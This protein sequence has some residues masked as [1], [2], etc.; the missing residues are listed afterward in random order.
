MAVRFKIGKERYSYPQDWRDVTLGEFV[1]FFEQVEALKPK[2]A[3][4]VQKL[5]DEIVE[6][7]GTTKAALEKQVQQLM[8]GLTEQEYDAEYVP[9]KAAYVSFYCK[10]DALNT[11]SVGEIEALYAQIN[12]NLAGTPKYSESELKSLTFAGTVYKFPNAGLRG[13]VA[14]EYFSANQ[15]IDNLSHLEHGE[16]ASLP[17]IMGVFLRPENTPFKAVEAK[18]R[19]KQFLDMPMSEAWKFYFFL[20]R[21]NLQSKSILTYF[22]IVRAS[23]TAP[24]YK[25]KNTGGY[26][27]KSK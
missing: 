3:K 12:S 7:E 19:A 16:Y 25:R 26:L 10:V 17:D 15:I 21:L 11:F 1:R 2:R 20:Q 6:S 5:L 18:A 23:L 4:E 9:Y 24:K 13:A 22:S 14:S 27:S 8:D